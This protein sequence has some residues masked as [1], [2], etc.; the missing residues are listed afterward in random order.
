MRVRERWAAVGLAGAVLAGAPGA[1]FGAAA[2]EF[3]PLLEVRLRHEIMD[4][5]YYFAPE[6]D[7]NWVRVRTRAGLRV[8]AAAADGGRHGGEV[9]LN[10][11]HRHVVT[12]GGGEF[13]WDEVILETACWRWR[14]AD[15][16]LLTVG[17]Q[18][19]VWPGGF[20]MMD[21]NPLDG[22]RTMYH[23]AVRLQTGLQTGLATR[24]GRTG[25]DLAFIHN[26][27]RD[28]LVL[29]D[30][31]ERD[32]C[33]AD[34]TALAMRLVRE[35]WAWSVITKVERDPDGRLPELTTTTFA[36]RRD[37]KSAPG[38]AWHLELALQHQEGRVA[39]AAQPAIDPGPA[40]WALAGE[41]AVS[42]PLGSG[43]RAQGG[44]FFYSG[45]GEDLRPFRT[46]WGR[47]PKW[48]DLTIY[49]LMGEN[50]PGRV[51]GAAWENI[52]APHVTVSRPLGG[53]SLVRQLTASVNATWLLAPAPSWQ[54]RGLLTR[55]QLTADLG[56]RL[57]GHLLWE[58][59]APGGFHD[60][61][62]GLRPW[63]AT[64]HFVRWQLV[65]SL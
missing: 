17:R 8:T 37:A 54:T 36:A 39:D 26:P 50:T 23:N 58:M 27:K 38:G 32:L 2:P 13:D 16:L 55:A 46:P 41:G 52:A 19:I 15:D 49:S 9:V 10:N 29:I 31:L 57:Q 20:L 45:L 3:E 44:A 6:P 33:D 11:E 18:D 61:R 65:W 63:T 62:N 43:W 4:G 42:R 24:A 28:P 53:G 51:H 30:D 7:R 12:P 21:G 1:G 56:P 47:W 64:G 25:L 22:S 60:G 5:V 59:L 48:S 40:G 34:E 35:G 14:A